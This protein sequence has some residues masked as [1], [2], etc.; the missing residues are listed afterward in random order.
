MFSSSQIIINSSNTLPQLRSKQ[1]VLARSPV[2][3][4][5]FPELSLWQ[6]SEVRQRQ[7]LENIDAYMLEETRL[8]LKRV[9]SLCCKLVLTDLTKFNIKL[10]VSR[11]TAALLITGTFEEKEQLSKLINQDSWLTGAFIWLC[12]N[13]NTLAH[14]QELRAFSYVYEKNRQQALQQYKHF[15]QSEQGMCCY[16]AC[17]IE[18]SEPRL[19]WCL[20]SPK[21]VYILNEL[22]G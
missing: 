9:R 6:N 8:I 3:D 10:Q 21:T 5:L 19:E 13:Y 7:I 4:C 14:S 16:L 15:A 12:P 11:S 20:E 18:T 2:I 1:S 17:N 22:Q